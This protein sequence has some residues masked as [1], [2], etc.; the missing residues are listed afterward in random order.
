MASNQRGQLTPTVT[1]RRGTA[2]FTVEQQD[3]YVR[4]DQSI[5]DHARYTPEE[6][7]E[8]AQAILDA[9]EAADADSP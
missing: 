1:P 6:A 3:G 2:Y 8:V 4:I 7:R 5:G 9:A